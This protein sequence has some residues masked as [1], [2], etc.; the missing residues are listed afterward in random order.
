MPAY[1]IRM[2]R[3]GDGDRTKLRKL[4]TTLC[5]FVGLQNDNNL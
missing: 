4:A 1:Q 5:A 2:G 3:L